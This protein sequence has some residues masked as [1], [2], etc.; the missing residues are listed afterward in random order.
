MTNSRYSSLSWQ[1]SVTRWCSVYTTP[2][3]QYSTEIARNRRSCILC[4]RTSDGSQSFSMY[5]TSLVTRYST[6]FCMPISSKNCCVKYL[7]SRIMFPSKAMKPN[8]SVDWRAI[9]CRMSFGTCY[10]TISFRMLLTSKMLWITKQVEELPIQLSKRIQKKK[11]P[12]A[13]KCLVKWAWL[14][15]KVEKKGKQDRV[16]HLYMNN[17]KE[18]WKSP[19][20]RLRLTRTDFQDRKLMMEKSSK[21][22]SKIWQGPKLPQTRSRNLLAKIF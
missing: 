14:E 4:W 19:F 10:L 20:R 1:K 16:I 18:S 5:M 15:E 3:C 2:K 7:G 6:N 12:T 13:S 11:D 21:T 17:R 22:Q 9:Y 8:F